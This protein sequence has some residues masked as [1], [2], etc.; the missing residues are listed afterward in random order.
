VVTLAWPAA[1]QEPTGEGAIETARELGLA[2]G[3]LLDKGQ[4]AEALE[5][6]E[7]AYRIYPA[8]TIGL[9]SAQAMARMGRLIEASDR[10]LEIA[11]RRPQPGD[12]PAFAKARQEAERERA[13]LGKKIPR[14]IVEVK[15]AALS[16]VSLRLDGAPVPSTLVGIEHRVNPGRHLLE[17]EWRGQRVS[18]GFELAE[19]EKRSVVLAFVVEASTKPAPKP[20]VAEAEKPEA[21]AIEAA[22]EDAERPWTLFVLDSIN[23][24]VRKGV[25]ACEASNTP[26]IGVTRRLVAPFGIRLRQTVAR[27]ARIG[28]QTNCDNVRWGGGSTLGVA[29]LFDWAGIEWVPHL[30][31]HIRLDDSADTYGFET[32]LET[33]HVI[34]GPL[35]FIVGAGFQLIYE[36]SPEGRK[37]LG[38]VP[39]AVGLGFGF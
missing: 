13:A 17:G 14:V 7:R 25:D 29:L 36:P 5:K 26:S 9:W 3:Q 2:G 30:G 11:R 39:I 4:Y 8:P 20:A 1:G 27:F 37:A 6:L 18:S 16:D 10:Y 33:R 35:V 22:K 38:V 21:P 32:G 15:G 24:T 28:G 34:T 31:F 12:S 23:P 19:A